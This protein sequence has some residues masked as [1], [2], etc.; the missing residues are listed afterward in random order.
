[1]DPDWNV[2]ETI[3]RSGGY[4]YR[5]YPYKV[6]GEGFFIAAFKKDGEDSQ[7]AR[8]KNKLQLPTKEE[9]EVLKPFL[10]NFAAFS[11]FKWQQD[12]TIE[13]HL[14]GWIILRYKGLALGWIKVL[15]NRINNYYPQRWRILNK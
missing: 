7:E 5:F 12:I 11:F 6:K 14:K 15:P 10:K 1:P 13:T 2:V 4:G 3:S 9:L 8:S